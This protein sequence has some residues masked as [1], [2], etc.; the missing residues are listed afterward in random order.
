MEKTPENHLV[1]PIE[2]S[3]QLSTSTYNHTSTKYLSD[4]KS[5]QVCVTKFV[6]F[7]EINFQQIYQYF[8]IFDVNLA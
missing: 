4:L 8:A 1:D 5:Q 3:K 2:K 7:E 6:I